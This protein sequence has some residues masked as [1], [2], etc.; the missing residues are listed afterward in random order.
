MVGAGGFEPPTFC[1][2]SK[3]SIQADL[4][5]DNKMVSVVGFEPTTPRFQNECDKSRLRHTLINDIL[6]KFHH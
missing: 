1:S 2:Q 3:R 5:T 4:C 6:K